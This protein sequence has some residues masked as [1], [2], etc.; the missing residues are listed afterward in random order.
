L[1]FGTETAIF[2]K[3]GILH[4]AVSQ[5]FTIIYGLIGVCRLSIN[6][7]QAARGSAMLGSIIKMFGGLTQPWEQKSKGAIIF[8]MIASL[9]LGGIEITKTL[10]AALREPSLFVAIW[11]V[12]GSCIVTLIVV[13]WLRGGITEL[14]RR[15]RSMMQNL[16]HQPPT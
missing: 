8:I 4:D 6:D 9:I 14:R 10:T 12:A 13:I 15:R 7:L 5:L 2:L 1:E 16:E 11:E 3:T